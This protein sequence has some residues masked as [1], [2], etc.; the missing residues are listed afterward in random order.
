MSASELP[1]ETPALL[2][3]TSMSHPAPLPCR[4]VGHVEVLD[5][6]TGLPTRAHWVSPR[7]TKNAACPHPQPGVAGAA[8]HRKCEMTVLFE[9]V[10]T[11]DSPQSLPLKAAEGLSEEGPA[12]EC[13]D[14]VMSGR[15]AQSVVLGLIPVGAATASGVLGNSLSTAATV[16][17]L[18][19]VATSVAAWVI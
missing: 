17:V 13:E 4:R 8:N 7:A 15:A 10:A 1:S 14:C 16:L 18:L 2:R 3:S 11:R 9:P 19:V 5:P 6:Q 12:R